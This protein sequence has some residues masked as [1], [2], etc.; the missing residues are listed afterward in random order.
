MFKS[1]IAV[2]QVLFACLF[3]VA[4]FTAAHLLRTAAGILS[5]APLWAASL[6]FAATA[7]AL[8]AAALFIVRAAVR[9]Q[10]RC[11]ATAGKEGT[12]F[13]VDSLSLSIAAFGML[14]A[15]LFNPDSSPLVYYGVT[16]ACVLFTAAGACR[17]NLGG[18]VILSTVAQLAFPLLVPAAVLVWVVLRLSCRLKTEEE[19]GVRRPRRLLRVLET[20]ARLTVLSH[21]RPEAK[22][23]I[24]LL[25][26]R[27]DRADISMTAAMTPL[28]AALLL[29]F[30][31]TLL[32]DTDGESVTTPR[33]QG[34]ALTGDR[35]EIKNARPFLLVSFF[36]GQIPLFSKD[37]P[38]C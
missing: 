17:V 6:V 5:E 31:A 4:F 22:E 27:E 24:K 26:L 1:T 12:V 29:G 14:C 23:R 28:A 36:D 38:R 20:A 30:A 25:A 9:Q 34:L 32:S 2:R 18:E 8:A 15:L 21:A 19:K 33:W 37:G 3:T 16:G 13:F 35:Q 10:R 11:L 7:P